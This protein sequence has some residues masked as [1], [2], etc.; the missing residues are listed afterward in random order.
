MQI[1][2]KG[3][4]KVCH[5]TNPLPQLSTSNMAR[6]N[7]SKKSLL[8]LSPIFFCLTQ[9]NQW[10][11]SNRLHIDT[12][13]CFIST[14]KNQWLLF[15]FSVKTNP[16]STACE[17][18]QNLKTNLLNTYKPLVCTIFVCIKNLFGE[19]GSSHCVLTLHFVISFAI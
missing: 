19:Q 5:S 16:T 8:V 18:V 12:L 14:N 6:K 3:N 4:S 2:F 13:V 10:A 11:F 17:H 9:E 1:I 15:Y 7:K